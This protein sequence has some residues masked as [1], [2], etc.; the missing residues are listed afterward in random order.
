[1]VITSK[2]FIPLVKK[3]EVG[4]F[5]YPFGINNISRKKKNVKLFFISKWVWKKDYDQLVW[6]L[7]FVRYCMF[8]TGGSGVHILEYG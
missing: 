5:S 6:Y 4:Q 3:N 8:A 2:V 1:M 7:F